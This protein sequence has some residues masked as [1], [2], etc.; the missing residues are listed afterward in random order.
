MYII[1]INTLPLQNAPLT[2]VKPIGHEHWKLP[3]VLSQICS[4][5]PFLSA[6]S[7]ISLHSYCK[8]RKINY[9]IITSAVSSI[10]C[11]SFSTQTL[12]AS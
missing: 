2:K 3:G 11:K 4:Q 10:A 9:H 8:M 1:K 5:P 12:I 7:L 6:H